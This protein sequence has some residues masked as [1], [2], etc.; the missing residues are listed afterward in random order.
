MRRQISE[1]QMLW[2][3]IAVII[4][5]DALWAWAMGMTIAP[6]LEATSVC[7]MFIAINIFYTTVRPNPMI[8]VFAATTAQL[9]AF[10]AS[11]VVLSYLTAT[12]KFPLIDRYLATADFAIGLDWLWLFNWVSEHPAIGRVL[13]L[14]YGTGLFQI[15]ALVVLL[16]A[17]GRLERLR[18]FLWLFVL[19]S[20][21]TI[22][23]S[24]IMPAAGAWAHY[25]VS[26]LTSAYYLPDFYALRSGEMREIEMAKIT[27]IVQFPSFHAATALA[28]IYVTRGIQYLFQVACVL[29][30]VMIASAPVYGGHHFVDIF[31]GLAVLP[32]AVFILR[33][34]QRDPPGRLVVAFDSNSPIRD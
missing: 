8:A 20:L 24:G 32:L 22:P 31:A 16:P 11:S 14:S 7:L 12:A 23:L 1:N 17:L 28:L 26:H 6:H 2:A 33:A 29:N 15:L 3:I 10:M 25:G 5:V 13:A 21:I 27:G 18:E 30:I 4:G 19:T 34:W 9:I